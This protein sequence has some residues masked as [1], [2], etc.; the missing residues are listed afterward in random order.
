MV[1]LRTTIRAI[2]ALKSNF[3]LQGKYYFEVVLS[4][5]E[6][7]NN[8]GSLRDRD[9]ESK[10]RGKEYADGKRHAKPNEIQKGDEVLLKRQKK[11]NKLA[12]TFEP[13]VYKVL[14]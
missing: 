5:R 14:K 10:E 4:L 2:N 3:A 9:E 13:T 12:S 11:A 7:N 8:D 6:V 1:L